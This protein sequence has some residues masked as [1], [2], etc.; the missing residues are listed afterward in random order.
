MR[1]PYHRQ[2]TTSALLLLA[3]A[4]QSYAV[5]D[6]DDADPSIQYSTGAIGWDHKNPSIANNS[7][8]ATQAFDST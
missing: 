7:A 6:I 5:V 2:L 4:I 1:G 3:W 8:D